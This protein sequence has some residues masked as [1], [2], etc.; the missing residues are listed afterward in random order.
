MEF[1][2]KYILITVFSP[3][4]SALIVGLTCRVINNKLAHVITTGMVLISAIFSLKILY[5][6]S[7]ENAKTF[8]TTS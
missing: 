5:I 1:L 4:L 6:Y 2:N 7:F 8:E 3:L